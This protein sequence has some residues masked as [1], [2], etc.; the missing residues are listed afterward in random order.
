[1]D[2][3]EARWIGKDL[4][5]CFYVSPDGK[6][7]EVWEVICK[8]V[9]ESQLTETTNCGLNYWESEDHPVIA[10][11]SEPHEDLYFSKPTENPSALLGILW[12][13]HRKATDNW[14]PFDRY[15][16]RQVT[17][18]ELFESDMGMLAS[19]PS[20]LIEAYAS[21][22]DNEGMKPRRLAS[23][24]GIY[25]PEA[26]MIHFSESYVVAETFEA[27]RIRDHK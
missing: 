18:R 26:K 15:I 22:I 21:A 6:T 3:S 2:L 12:K 4:A 11:Y 14:I 19:G 5:L 23:E 8:S 27:S 25:V 10:Q 7:Q 17:P 16:N 24:E 1:M 13:V 20:Y 9:V